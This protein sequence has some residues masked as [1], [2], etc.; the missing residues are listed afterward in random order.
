[1]SNVT[2]TPESVSTVF[3]VA[4][5]FLIISAL[6]DLISELTSSIALVWTWMVFYY[7]GFVVFAYLLYKTGETYHNAKG[8]LN[9]AMV[10]LIISLIIDLL[11]FLGMWFGWFFMF[12]T[13]M[14]V[15]MIFAA[16]IL[17]G[18]AFTL[19]HIGFTK[20]SK[21]IGNPIYVI[22]GWVGLLFLTIFWVTLSPVDDIVSNIGTYVDIALLALIAVVLV[23]KSNDIKQIAAQPRHLT[24][25]QYGQTYQP[26]STYQPP[27]SQQTQL[28]QAYVPQ[29]AQPAKAFCSHCGGTVSGDDK[30]CENCGAKVE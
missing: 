21:K 26:Y 20:V 18:I 5:G 6:L 12:Y 4:A 7:L 27:Q 9:G 29:A 10:V 1:M 23:V 22:F 16:S 24:V 25:P 3:K 15:I 30:F 14:G 17:R 2:N 11:L 13:M 8:S 28:T 19:A